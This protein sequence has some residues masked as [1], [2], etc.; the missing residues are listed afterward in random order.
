M[1]L[2]ALLLR[3]ARY[4]NPLTRGNRE[5]PTGCHRVPPRA[6]RSD[7]KKETQANLSIKFRKWACF[8]SRGAGGGLGTNP[9]SPK[10][11][12]F[13]NTRKTRENRYVSCFDH[14]RELGCVGFYFWVRGVCI[15]LPTDT[16]LHGSS[17]F[18]NSAVSLS[19]SFV[20]CEDFIWALLQITRRN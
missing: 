1:R 19:L 20:I 4:Q 6:C 18:L 2:L 11:Q 8:A 17:I 16:G 15:G 14:L 7:K 3:T 9:K 13:L 5:I 12:N 10:I